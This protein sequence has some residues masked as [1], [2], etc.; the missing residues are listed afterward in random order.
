MP[1]LADFTRWH[2]PP[3]FETFEVVQ[4]TRGTTTQQGPAKSPNR[5]PVEYHYG[6]GHHD[7]L[8]DGNWLIVRRGNYR[9]YSK[10]GYFLGT[11]TPEGGYGCGGQNTAQAAGARAAEPVAAQRE[12]A[13]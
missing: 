10:P 11:Y 12:T 5:G 6:V 9:S 3:G 7:Q 1:T 2:V 13:R 8:P 4:K